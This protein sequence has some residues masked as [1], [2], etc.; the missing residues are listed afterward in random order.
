ME[1]TELGSCPCCITPIVVTL[2]VGAWVGVLAFRAAA[3]V[4]AP[5]SGPPSVV[6]CCLMTIII[7]FVIAALGLAALAG[8][9]P[10][11]D[12]TSA[13]LFNKLAKSQRMEP[14]R[15]SVVGNATGDVLEFGPGPG[16][17]FQ[18]W[19][20]GIGP[21][22]WVGVEPNGYFNDMVEAEARARDL[23]FPKEI[24]GLKGE[25]ADVPAGTFDTVVIT[26]V[27]CSVDS[28]QKV[29]WQAHRALK[30]GGQMLLMEN[31]AAPKGT[32]IWYMQK[33]VGPI[34][35]IVSNGCD[36]KETWRSLDAVVTSKQFEGS[37]K[38]VDA[39]IPIPFLKPHIVGSFSKVA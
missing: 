21:E 6:S 38:H 7:L 32:G 36:F 25:I 20:D 19:W 22:S 35:N 11:Q 5:K 10:L 14:L 2:L 29:L 24:L 8:V 9:K 15:C 23:T 17:N 33:L 34:F 39:P 28:V 18:C 4:V 1:E 13:Q 16:T 27:L 30:P 31:V 26:H 12:F 3:R 37:Y